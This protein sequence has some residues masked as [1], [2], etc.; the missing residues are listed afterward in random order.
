MF[1]VIVT[2]RTGRMQRLPVHACV[3]FQAHEQTAYN[4]QAWKQKVKKKQKDTV[5]YKT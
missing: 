2:E 1:D 5:A 4:F 3:I